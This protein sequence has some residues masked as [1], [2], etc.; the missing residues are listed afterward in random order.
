M[1]REDENRTD[2]IITRLFDSP[3]V[4]VWKA[5]TEPRRVMRWW[6]PKGFTSPVSRIDLA[7]GRRVSQLH[8]V[9]RG[10]GLLEQRRL[11]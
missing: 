9:A 11:S 6:G 2:L 7:S 10:Q 1:A 4:L 5:W 3:R 8:E